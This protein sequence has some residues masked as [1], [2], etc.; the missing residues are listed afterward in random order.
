MNVRR[1]SD[2]QEVPPPLCFVAVLRLVEDSQGKR[3]Q[4][5]LSRAQVSE[6]REAADKNR[7]PKEQTEEQPAQGKGAEPNGRLERT[8]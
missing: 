1:V 3:Q 7:E 6:G 4:T 2:R 8:H 5:D